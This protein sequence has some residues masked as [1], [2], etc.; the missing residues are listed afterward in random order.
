[1]W[2]TRS[3]RLA[4]NEQRMTEDVQDALRPSA[5]DA[6]RAWS[7]R[8]RANREQVEQFR[9]ASPADFYAPIAGMFRADPRRQD[10]PTLESLRALVR[11]SDVVLDVGAGGGRYA[12]PLA[13]G[14]Q[15]VIAVDPSEGMLG[16]LRDGMAAHGISNIRVLGGRW[17]A[18]AAG[19][20]ADVVLIAHLGYDVEDIG[21]FLDAMETAARR[22]CVAVLLDQ[23]PP[24]EAD[25]FWPA[26]HGVERAALPSLPEFLA[27]LR[28]RDRLFEVQRVDRSPLAYA[29]PDHA[30]AWLRGQLWVQPDGPKDVLLQRLMRERIEE[31][32]GRYALSWAPARVGIVTWQA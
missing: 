11:P 24:I 17:P 16:V 19:L 20:E 7:G 8:V 30:L 28:A 4:N 29:Q 26:V 21:P 14:V 13:L 10:E 5:L 22:T 12:L 1:M 25:R 31:R 9:E 2:S 23:P 32:N 27:L 3:F 15:E 18:I 6:L